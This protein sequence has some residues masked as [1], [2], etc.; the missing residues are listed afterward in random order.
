[1]P[2]NQNAIFR[3]AP[4]PECHISSMPRNQNAIFRPAPKPECHI[5]TSPETRMPYFDQPRSQNAWFR[6]A[7][8]PEC[9]ISRPKKTLFL[10]FWSV[11]RSERA[12]STI[13]PSYIMPNGTYG[14]KKKICD[15]LP[16]MDGWIF[17]ESLSSSSI[18]RC[19]WTIM[20]CN[21]WYCKNANL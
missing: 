18:V 19:Y 15:T 20:V 10:H 7:P 2:R 6:P 5:S 14:R 4:K 1:M 17:I 11:F 21:S 12:V 9:Q 8:K 16:L 13:F 3:P